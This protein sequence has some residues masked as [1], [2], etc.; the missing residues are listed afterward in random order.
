MTD[1]KKA[2]LV[3]V[4]RILDYPNQPF[5]EERSSMFSFIHENISSEDVRKEVINRIY[6]LYEMSLK[7]LQELFVETFDYKEK[8]NLYLTAHEL[9]DSR[10]RGIALIQLQKLIFEAGFDFVGKEL[11]DY[12]PMLLEFLAVVPEEGRFI[13]L[14]SRVAYAIQRILNNLSDSNPYFP[15]VELLQLFVFEASGLEEISKLEYLRE[16]A[17]LD[18]LPFPLMYR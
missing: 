5:F 3:V 1:E 14:S 11:A 15:A 13:N 16:E 17:D 8:T 12:I 2:I 6:P 7:D 10:K 4:S 9:G 18:E